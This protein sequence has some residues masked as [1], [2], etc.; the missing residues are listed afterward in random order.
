MGANTFLDFSYGK[1]MDEAFRRA[2][3]QAQWEYGHGGYTGTIA[4]KYD[5]V[6]AGQLPARMSARRVEQAFSDFSVAGTLPRTP[7]I[8]TLVETYG[9][10]YDDKWGPAVGFEVGGKTAK[11]YKA[12]HGLTGTRNRVYVFMGWASS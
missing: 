9:A 6:D 8:R 7:S 5:C 12:R 11:E 1:N 3:D 10:A 4:E 2:V